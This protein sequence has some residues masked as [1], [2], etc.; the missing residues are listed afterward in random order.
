MFASI[1][2]MFIRPSVEAVIHEDLYQAQR[3]L[4]EAEANSEAWNA[5]VQVYRTRVSRLTRKI[6]ETKSA[7]RITDTGLS[8][9]NF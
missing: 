1:K 3:D 4:L 2:A 6:D 5:K 8:P 9:A 7:P